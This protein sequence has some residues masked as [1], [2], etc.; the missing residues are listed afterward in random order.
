MNYWLEN[1]LNTHSIFMN[2]ESNEEGSMII[3]CFNFNLEVSS[4]IRVVGEHPASTFTIG[5]FVIVLATDNDPFWVAQVTETKE[6]C[7]YFNYYHYK[8]GSKQQKIWYEH[9]SNGS[10]GFLDVLVRFRNESEL[11]TKN[12]TIR[13]QAQNKISQALAV[14][15]GRY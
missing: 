12:K 14:Y 15:T 6:D 11:F 13:K 2:D 9:E 8:I 10:C 7:V 5:D 1:N 4:S 3:F